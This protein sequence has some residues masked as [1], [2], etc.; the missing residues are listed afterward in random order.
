MAFSTTQ[1]RQNNSLQPTLDATN[2]LSAQEL[3]FLLDAL[4]RT[5]FVGEQVETMFNTVLKLQNQ[6]LEQTKQ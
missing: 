5:T 3:V 1:L 6:Y 2:Q 4:K